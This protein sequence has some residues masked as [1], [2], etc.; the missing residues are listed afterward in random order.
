M[1]YLTLIT[2][3]S[4]FAAFSLFKKF[5]VIVFDKLLNLYYFVYSGPSETVRE[6]N[7]YFNWSFITLFY[8]LSLF[9]KNGEVIFIFGLV[10]YFQTDQVIFVP[11]WPK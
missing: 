9:D 1:Q 2:C 11:E 6:S 4:N 5:S 7:F 10:M 3:D 8:P